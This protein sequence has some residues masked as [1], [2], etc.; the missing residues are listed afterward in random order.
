MRWLAM[1]VLGAVGVVMGAPTPDDAEPARLPPAPAQELVPGGEDGTPGQRID[2]HRVWQAFFDGCTRGRQDTEHLCAC[3]AT[4]SLDKCEREAGGSAAAVAACIQNMDAREA[5]REC[6][7]YG[8]LTTGGPVP[9]AQVMRHGPPPPGSASTTRV[10]RWTGSFQGCMRAAT[11]AERARA[12]SM[13]YTCACLAT[14][15]VNACAPQDDTANEQV[16]HCVNVM[17]D[18]HLQSVSVRCDAWGSVRMRN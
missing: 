13:A 1:L 2:Q 15:I 10:D 4:Y 3:A 9:P 5:A 7:N 11:P 18:P 8:A 14:Y 12:P 16:Q 6:T 17:G